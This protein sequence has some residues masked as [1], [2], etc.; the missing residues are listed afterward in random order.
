MHHN[1]DHQPPERMLDPIKLSSWVFTLFGLL[2]ANWLPI[3]P[4]NRRAVILIL[5][6]FSVY[7]LVYFEW[8]WPRY[9]EK[10]WLAV[11]PAFVN[12]VSLTALNYFLGPGLSVEIIYI[13]IVVN[14][15]IRLGKRWA[16][17]AA[18]FS[19]L[20]ILGVDLLNW[21]NRTGG[22]VFSSGLNSLACLV[23][24]FLCGSMADLIRKQTRQAQALQRAVQVQAERISV[25]NEVARQIGSTIEMDA[26]LDLIYQQVSRTISTDT[27]FVGIHESS[28]DYIELPI[29]YDDG[30]QWPK[31]RIPLGQGLASIVIQGRAPLRIGCLSEI[32][33]KMPIPPVKVGAGGYSESWLGVPMQMSDEFSGLLAVA[34]YQVNAFSEEDQALLT[35]IASQIALALD[36]ARHHAQVEEQSRRDSLTGVYNHGYLL[37]R[38]QE[39]IDR[40][41]LSGQPLSLIMLDIDYFKNYNDAYGHLMGDQVLRLIVQAIQ[42]H[43]KKTD[44]VGRWG[45]EEFGV[46]LTNATAEQSAVVADRIRASLA[47]L[48]LV[49][50]AGF[51]IPNPTVSQG[52]ATLAEPIKDAIGLVDL[53]DAMLYQ[54]KNHGRDQ[55]RVA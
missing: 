24:G 10:E 30:K 47:E 22:I 15:A 31:F 43:V 8:L 36:N 34:S 55:V 33:D 6:A 7:L 38:L 26:L 41:R 46:V 28:W 42:A 53:S 16:M 2:V 18:V 45:G 50:K 44:V 54:A 27:Y 21:T 49:N 29:V 52:I 11:V 20:M 5:L 4:D 32:R 3:S 23:A 17:V 40:A 12:I 14:A 13:I 9:K 39:E 48:S 51:A 25:V 35:N 37:L 1:L 19:A